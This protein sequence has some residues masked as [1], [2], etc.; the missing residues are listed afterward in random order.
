VFSSDGCLCNV[1]W[2]QTKYWSMQSYGTFT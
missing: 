1:P 2:Q